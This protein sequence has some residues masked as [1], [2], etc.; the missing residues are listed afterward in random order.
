LI[1][2][3]PVEGGA[4]ARPQIAGPVFPPARKRS[5][6]LGS[7]ARSTNCLIQVNSYSIAS[8][9]ASTYPIAWRSAPRLRYSV[10]T[11]CVPSSVPPPTASS[12]YRLAFSARS[13]SVP[14]WRLPLKHGLVNQRHAAHTSRG[15]A[16]S[17][18]PSV[19][20]SLHLHQFQGST[21]LSAL[22][23][24]SPHIDHSLPVK[25]HA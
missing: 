12:R 16:S 9:G 17:A 14:P 20:G 5:A 10:R 24:Y 6:P 3:L 15:P 1:A 22:T 19:R 8:K 21:V 18:T 2:T 11:R 7:R 25:G 23:H 4:S 13:S